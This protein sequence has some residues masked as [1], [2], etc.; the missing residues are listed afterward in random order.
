MK[1]IHEKSKWIE[2]YLYFY[3]RNFAPSRERKKSINWE[4]HLLVLYENQ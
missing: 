1:I 3:D 2:R 4:R